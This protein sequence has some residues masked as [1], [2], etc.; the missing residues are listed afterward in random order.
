MFSGDGDEPRGKAGNVKAAPK[1]L[2]AEIDHDT[3]L[4]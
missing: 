4:L 2:H 1:E 3:G